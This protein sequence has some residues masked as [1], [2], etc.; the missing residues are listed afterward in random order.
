MSKQNLLSRKAFVRILAGSGLGFMAWTWYRLGERQALRNDATAYRHTAVPAGVSF[1][2][3]Y[4]LYR[5][6]NLVKAY[7]AT[8]THA[9]CRLLSTN[10]EIIHCGCHGSQFEAATGKSLKGPAINP[11][12]QLECEYHA[13]SGEWIVKF[14]PAEN[15]ISP[16][17]KI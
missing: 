6:E 9:G 15:K 3:K 13:E 17:G 12:E 16:S 5:R 10:A 8:C 14:K 11:L 2:G 4:Y 7:S 1:H